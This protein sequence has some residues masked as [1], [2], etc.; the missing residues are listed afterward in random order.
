[1][2]KM[3]RY[4]YGKS[5]ERRKELKVLRKQESVFLE[6]T[7][8]IF[9]RQLDRGADVLAENPW[10]SDARQEGPTQKLLE[11]KEVLQVRTHMCQ[12]GLRHRFDG[13]PLRKDTWLLVTSPEMAAEVHKLCPGNHTYGHCFGGSKVT[14][15]AGRYTPAFA[16]AVLRGL[17]RTLARKEPSRLRRMLWHVEKQ[18]A[19]AGLGASE[20]LVRL[21]A[22][23]R[24]ECGQ[25]PCH[26]DRQ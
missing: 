3:A 10:T 21:A 9:E 16:R 26:A 20:S 13:R 8:E 15:A 5:P 17:R 7:R 14:E 25:A 11:H 19:T 4:N 24:R 1:M 22:S 23:L 18:I 6:L 12:F 2:G